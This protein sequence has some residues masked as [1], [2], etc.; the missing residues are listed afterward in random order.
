ML[1]LLPVPALASA[2]AAVPPMDTVSPPTTLPR[3]VP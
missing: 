2:K 1:T 3:V